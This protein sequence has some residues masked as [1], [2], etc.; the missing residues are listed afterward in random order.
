MV[1]QAF[2]ESLSGGVRALGP[3]RALDR[4]IAGPPVTVG[5]LFE[6][7]RRAIDAIR[8][9]VGPVDRGRLSLGASSRPGGLSDGDDQ[10]GDL[11]LARDRE[12]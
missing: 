4:A 11:S 9:R 1:K 3:L 12:R 8:A 5:A 10:R 7:T 6:A 2:A